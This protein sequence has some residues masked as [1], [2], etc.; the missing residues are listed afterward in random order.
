MNE[1]A[2]RITV[3]MAEL[4][5]LHT[6]VKD[7]VKTERYYGPIL[8]ADQLDIWLRSFEHEV[9]SK[10]ERI[11]ADIVFLGQTIVERRENAD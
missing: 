2:T 11:Y 10:L 9:T 4:Q 5:A 8:G 1:L 3:L 7:E 6:Y